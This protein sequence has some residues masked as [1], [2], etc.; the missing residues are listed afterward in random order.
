[1]GREEGKQVHFLRLWTS[2]VCKDLGDAYEI[3]IYKLGHLEIPHLEEKERRGKEEGRIEKQR[4]IGVQEGR[5]EGKQEEDKK[6][7]GRMEKERINSAKRS[8][9]KDTWEEKRTGQHGAGS[10]VGMSES[11]VRRKYC[12]G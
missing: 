5:Q 2:F 1:M 7:E 9:C 4:I 6:E 11:P 3:V 8:V 12:G 10:R